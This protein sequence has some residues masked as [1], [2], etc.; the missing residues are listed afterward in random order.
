M[1]WA[2]LVDSTKIIKTGS[3]RQI[4]EMTEIQIF[5]TD[6]NS[7]VTSRTVGAEASGG[8]RRPPESAGVLRSRAESS[9]NPVEFSG[10]P[11][12]FSGLQW[13]S[14]DSGGD[15]LNP[16]EIRWI[17]WRSGGVLRNP[18]EFSGLRWRSVESAGDPLD[19]LEIR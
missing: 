8:K 5:S 16:L 17:R 13:S 6:A 12:E 18:V 14:P 11:V 9:G 2:F 3:I 19:P 1:R 7:G 4:V 15:P 10:N